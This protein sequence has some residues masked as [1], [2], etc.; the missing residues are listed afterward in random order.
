[1]A[2]NAP[3]FVTALAATVAWTFTHA[4]DRL[5]ATPFLKYSI[6]EI[7]AGGKYNSYI[8]ISNITR[9]K[10][11]K[12]LHLLAT[13]STKD[14]VIG[15]SVI[16]QQPAFEGN[17]APIIA[18][19]TF[20]FTFPEIQPGWQFYISVLHNSADPVSIRFSSSDAQ[21]FYAIKPSLETYLLDHELPILFG[22]F[23][24]AVLALGFSLYR[25]APTIAGT[26]E[27]QQAH[28]D[29]AQQP[30]TSQQGHA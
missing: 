9:D 28:L 16:P 1:M 2:D 25:G 3:F 12:S 18:G 14:T 23:S 26:K 17:N 6:E 4:V 8:V 13:T 10:T 24:I 7:E 27:A 11:F 29:A 22:F 21:N 15:G 30:Q 5:V 20:A 19:R